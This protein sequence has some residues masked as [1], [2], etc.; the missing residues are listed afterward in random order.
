MY[1]LPNLLEASQSYTQDKP[2]LKLVLKSN[3]LL[4]FFEKGKRK[5]RKEREGRKEQRK[6]GRKINFLDFKMQLLREDSKGYLDIGWRL[7]NN[8]NKLSVSESKP[9]RFHFPSGKWVFGDTKYK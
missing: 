6:E 7:Q 3:F 1:F 5:E 2:K 9:D 4:T 8:T